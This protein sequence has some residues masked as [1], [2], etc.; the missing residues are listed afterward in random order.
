MM[1]SLVAIH[2]ILKWPM[3]AAVIVGVSSAY[4]GTFSPKARRILGAA[5]VGLLDLQL[6]LGGILLFEEGVLSTSARHVGFMVLTLILAHGFYIRA[7]KGGFADR[8]ARVLLF[9]VPSLTLGLGLLQ[10][11]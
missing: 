4:V 8:R 3:F 9:V 11:L 6:L 1:E 7:K 10:V 5:Y 2:G